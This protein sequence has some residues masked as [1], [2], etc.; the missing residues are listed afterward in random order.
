MSYQADDTISIE[1]AARFGRSFQNTDFISGRYGDIKSEAQAQYTGQWVAPVRAGKQPYVHQP[2]SFEGTTTHQED[3]KYRG[4]VPCKASETARGHNHVFANGLPFNGVTTAQHD[5]RR[6][7][8]KPARLAK[9]TDVRPVYVADERHFQ[10]EASSQFDFKNIQPRRSCAPE[11]HAAASLPF[12]G[13]STQQADFV[14]HDAPPAPSYARTRPYR[15]RQEDRSFTTE[16]RGSFADQF[17]SR[18]N[19]QAYMY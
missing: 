13:Q 7:N 1:E 3:F 10:T 6:W 2:R 11:L 15:R 18:P 12:D 17:G 9:E 14:R 5:F 8:A 4:A 19:S 16:S